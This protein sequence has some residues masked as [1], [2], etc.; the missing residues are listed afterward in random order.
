[1]ALSIHPTIVKLAIRLPIPTVG[2][3]VLPARRAAVGRT[4]TAT[5]P[6]PATAA[7]HASR[8][9]YPM[10]RPAPMTATIVPMTSAAPGCAHIRI[11]RP[12]SPAATIP[13]LIATIP[14][15]ATAPEFARATTRP[16]GPV[17]MTG[18]SAPMVRLVRLAFAEMDCRT[19]APTESPVPPISVMKVL[20]PA[21]IRFRPASA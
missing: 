7:A 15:L 4:P 3:R 14:T 17:V 9:T 10:V 5:T 18:S 12:V 20:I 16:M 11:A 6:T 13:S 1:M 19:T 8:I 21:K 2:L